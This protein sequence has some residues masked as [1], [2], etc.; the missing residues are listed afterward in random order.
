L[1]PVPHQHRIVRVIASQYSVQRSSLPF[2]SGIQPLPLERNVRRE[3]GKVKDAIGECQDWQ[4]LVP[5]AQ[6]VSDH[7]GGCKLVATAECEYE[8]GGLSDRATARQLSQDAV[9]NFPNSL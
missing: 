1:I 4:E 7:G 5:L 9:L 2:W 3:L 6:D 8:H